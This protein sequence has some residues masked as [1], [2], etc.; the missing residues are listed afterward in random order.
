MECVEVINLK[1]RIELE[2][3]Y[4]NIEIGYNN[5]KQKQI[6]CNNLVYYE[7]LVK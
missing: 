5:Y 2:C 3:Y 4:W 6:N 7:F 1:A